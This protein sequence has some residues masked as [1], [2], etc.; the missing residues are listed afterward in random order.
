M[1]SVMHYFKF[2]IAIFFIGVHTGLAQDN[3]ALSTYLKSQESIINIPQSINAPRFNAP[4]LDQVEI[5]TESDRLR[6]NRQR[7]SLRLTPMTPKIR[8]LQKNLYNDLAAL[9]A[10]ET[11]DVRHESIIESYT[12]WL[13]YYFIN[14]ELTLLKTKL[15][16]HSDLLNNAKKD[17]PNDAFDY[18][19]L[20][21]QER[22]VL[23]LKHKIAAL[24]LQQSW[25]P[26]FDEDNSL[27][28]SPEEI[29]ALV[30][31]NDLMVNNNASIQKAK[32]NLSKIANE[33]AIEKAKKNKVFDFVQMEYRGP[34]DEDLERKISFSAAFRLPM[35]GENKL[36]LAALDLERLGEQNEILIEEMNQEF[37]N[38]RSKIELKRIIQQ[39][40]LNVAQY[41]EILQNT[42]SI[43]GYIPQSKNEIK[44]ILEL[45]LDDINEA[46]DLLDQKKEIYESYLEWL[47]NSGKIFE[48]P[49]TNYLHPR[50]L[51]VH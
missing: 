31:S 17:L 27:L 11:S 45:K 38:T 40:Q 25:Y 18:I 9:H 5:R 21:E 41:K 39:Y 6:F 36:D 28:I 30:E 8:K 4:Y 2:T 26:Q 3:H 19:S 12:E 29:I 49:L 47:E 50:L 16:L 22:A 15:P 42:K 46:I 37:V 35:A 7:Y 43:E 51:S 32:L 44:D 24:E 14:E 33:K 23:R 13:A 1:I 10:F 48:L 20:V 34:H